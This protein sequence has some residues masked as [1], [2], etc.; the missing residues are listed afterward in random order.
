M[1]NLAIVLIIGVLTGYS[2]YLG[3]TELAATGLGCLAGVLVQSTKG[4]P[5]AKISTDPPVAV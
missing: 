3:N 5:N 2:L 4:V 1:N